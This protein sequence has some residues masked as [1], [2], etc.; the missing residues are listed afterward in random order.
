MKKSWTPKITSL[1]FNSTQTKTKL[2]LHIIL[3]RESAK[4]YSNNI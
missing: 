4:I 3:H 2:N 1:C